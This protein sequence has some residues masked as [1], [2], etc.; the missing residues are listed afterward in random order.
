MVFSWKVAIQDETTEPL[1]SAEKKTFPWIDE[2]H[3]LYVTVLAKNV[4]KEICKKLC[5]FLKKL[6]E[7]YNFIIFFKYWHLKNIIF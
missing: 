6:Q 1:F 5:L 2:T 3:T 4:L 7:M